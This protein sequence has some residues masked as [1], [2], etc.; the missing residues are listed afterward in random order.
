M[1]HTKRLPQPPLKLSHPESKRLIE[2]KKKKERKEKEAEK[3]KSE[4][5][6]EEEEDED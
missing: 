1:L 2:H 5:E 6:A 3:K 4:R